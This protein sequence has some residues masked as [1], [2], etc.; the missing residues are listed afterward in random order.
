MP[1]EERSLARNFTFHL[2]RIVTSLVT[3]K[4][5]YSISD[6][7][8]I[9]VDLIQDECLQSAYLKLNTIVEAYQQNYPN[10]NI[11]NVSKSQKFSDEISRQLR[12]EF[13]IT[14]S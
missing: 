12:V 9:D 2:A 11:I 8:D 10:E 13:P 5:H 1:K 6:L 14:A 4:A 3:E 7:K